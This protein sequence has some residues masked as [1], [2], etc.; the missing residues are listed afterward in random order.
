MDQMIEKIKTKNKCDAVTEEIINLIVGK[1]FKPGE[2]LPPENELVEMFGV[3]R[4][5]VRESL[6]RLSTMGIVS[7]YQGDGTFVNSFNLQNYMKP[8]FSMMVLSELSLEQ[9]YDARIYVEAGTASMAAKN[10]KPEHIVQLRQMLARQGETVEK[11]DGLAFTE[12]DGAFHLKIGEAADNE[13][14][15]SAYMLIK[16]ILKHYLKKTN[17]YEAVMQNSL[18]FHGEI[19]DAIESR[20]CD[21][22]E[23]LMRNHIITAKQALQDMLKEQ[24]EGKPTHE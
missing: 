4:V 8:L 13:I 12:L 19:V 6:K 1:T 21:S 3:S 16:D 24:K 15:M 9:L 22:A 2:R 20:D 14:L 17:R 10:R 23:S 18:R 7:I 5:T 11:E